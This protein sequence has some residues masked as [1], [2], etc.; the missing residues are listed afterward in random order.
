MDRTV[1][2]KLTHN[3]SGNHPGASKHPSFG[4]LGSRPCYRTHGTPLHVKG[5]S[6]FSSGYQSASTYSTLREVPPF[7]GGSLR[8]P[9]GWASKKIN[10]TSINMNR[11]FEP[12]V[13]NE[14]T[15][16]LSLTGDGPGGGHRGQ[17]RR[18][19]TSKGAPLV[20]SLSNS[21]GKQIQHKSESC[22]INART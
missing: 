4:K 19:D 3:L 9:A 22:K 16:F 1:R 2:D 13:E 10:K 14:Q 6:L 5:S 7:S 17:K 12:T 11:L 15:S 21:I 18:S 8:M 20:L